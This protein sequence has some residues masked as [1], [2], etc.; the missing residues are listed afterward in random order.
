M[1]KRLR[2]QGTYWIYMRG[3]SGIRGSLLSSIEA[4]NFHRRTII[5][6]LNT[7]E[8]NGKLSKKKFDGAIERLNVRGIKIRVEKYPQNKT[9]LKEYTDVIARRYETKT[10]F[11]TD[12]A[13]VALAMRFEEF[14]R[15]TIYK[16]LY[17]RSKENKRRQGS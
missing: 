6:E 3:V 9:E 13:I 5:N 8:F 15:R 1:E 16:I 14:L 10:R 17:R 4:L 12:Q 7:I 2:L 11:L